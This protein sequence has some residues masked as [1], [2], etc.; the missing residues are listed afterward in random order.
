[1]FRIDEKRF[2]EL[3]RLTVELFP[4][5]EDTSESLFE[6]HK[7]D[8]EKKKKRKSKDSSETPQGDSQ[9]KCPKRVGSSGPRGSFYNKYKFWRAEFKTSGLW[10]PDSHYN[11]NNENSDPNG[12][13]GIFFNHLIDHTEEN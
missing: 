1:M 12:D 10:I 13:S 7:K 3:K 11:S 6:A 9:P 5:F 4:K 8:K 2:E